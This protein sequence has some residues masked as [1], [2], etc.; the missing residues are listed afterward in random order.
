M[1]R[2]G[3][4]C[5]RRGRMTGFGAANRQREIVEMLRAEGKVTVSGLA[6][7]LDVSVV[8]VRSDLDT[9]ER[10][11]VLRRL[12]GGA[13][14]VRP[15]RF[16][17]A[18]NPLSDAFE[19]EKQRIGELAA[20]YVRNGETII[21]D[22]GT[23]TLALARA[24]PKTLQDV[25][26]VTPSL[27]VALELEAHP[28]VQVVVTGGRL[29]KV[30]QS[31][32]SPYGTLLLHQINADV[33]FI[34]CS[35]IDVAKGFTMRSWEE[36]EVTQSIIA[37]ASRVV[38]VADHGKLGHVGTAKTM[39]IEDADLLVTDS[40]APAASIRALQQSGLTVVTA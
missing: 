10:Q 20:S 1:G 13:I 36:V 19:A 32:I 35:G 3:R 38:V 16:H 21:I 34:S 9:L 4:P 22:S 26:V 14:A 31:L 28:G 23:T 5:C 24:L 40:G 29:S 6:A 33:A 37:A 39:S 27:P 17:R 2:R 25:A 18:M 7:A 11:Q 15:A 8:T 12:R 30:H